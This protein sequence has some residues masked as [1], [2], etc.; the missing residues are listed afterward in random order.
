VIDFLMDYCDGALDPQERALFDAHLAVCPDCVAYLN[1]YKRSV[2]LGTKAF[3]EPPPPLPTKL[4]QAIL[5][6]RKR[7]P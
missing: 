2:H 4:A 1:N 7:Q 5:A 6:A 3:D